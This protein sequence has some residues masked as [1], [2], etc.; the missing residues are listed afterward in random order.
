MIKPQP[1][2]LR[3]PLS[4]RGTAIALLLIGLLVVVA[5]LIRMSPDSSTEIA[6]MTW[7]RS[8]SAPGF[9]RLMDS[10]S[11]F[12]NQ[13]GITLA[14]VAAMVL[15]FAGRA[16]DAAVFIAVVLLVGASVFVAD[17]GLGEIAG[18]GRP[19]PVETNPSYPSGHTSG[20]TWFLI[21]LIFLVLRSSATEIGK[22]SVMGILGTLVLL[23]G[24][25]RVFLQRHWPLDVVGGYAL[26]ILAA[27]CAI[28]LFESLRRAHMA[29][30]NVV[31]QTTR[32]P[33][34]ELNF[35]D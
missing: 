1:V 24:L 34:S 15:L 19:I 22:G 30:D 31:S 13:P 26:G 23:V 32:N 29:N 12:T 4:Q 2:N 7:V 18:R 14:P 10:V 27:L 16:R 21:F 17:F 28:W 6:V 35:A 33:H 11:R 9:D 5:L 25:S 8:L 3:A 20:S